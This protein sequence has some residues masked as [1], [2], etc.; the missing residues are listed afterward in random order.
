MNI[1]VRYYSR[2]GNTKNLALAI[3]EELNVQAENLSSPLTEKADVL[4]LGSA[5]Y[6]SKIDD[7]VKR[8]IKENKDNIGIIYNFSTAAS[9][10]S[11]YKKVKKLAKENGIAISEK[12]FRC[13][14]K[15]LFL[16]KNR[17]NEK[18]LQNARQFA[19]NVLQETNNELI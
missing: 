10:S 7:E 14:G 8:F 11:T 13:R 12:E 5:I 4:F 2:T 3:A 19:R 1:A 16:N 18:D 17:P 15:F 9:P 6:A